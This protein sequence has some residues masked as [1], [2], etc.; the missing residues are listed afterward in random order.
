MRDANAFDRATTLLRRGDLAGAED[1]CLAALAIEP[2]RLDILGLAGVIALMSHRPEDAE[3]RLSRAVALEPNSFDNLSNLGTSYVRLGRFEEA[4]EAYR[5]AVSLRPKQISARLHLA[6]AY[7]ALRRYD[8]A[9][10]QL[11]PFA[12]GRDA[13]LHRE[14][15]E[16]SVLAG[17]LQAG[18]RSLRKAV[19]GL[20]DPKV[21]RQKLAAILRQSGQPEEAAREYRRLAEQAPEDGAVQADLGAAL[22]DMGDRAGAIAAYQRAV[23]L[24]PHDAALRARLGQLH[25]DVVPAWHFTMLGDEAR[26]TAYDAAIRAAVQP[27]AVVLDIGTGSGLLAMMAARAGAAHVYAC[28]AE[29]L[30]ADKAREIVAANG[31]SD[32]ITVIGKRSFDLRVGADLPVRAD[33]LLSEIVDV[34]LLGEGVLE[35][36][37]H[38]LASLVVPG[39]RIIPRGGAV[40]AMMVESPALYRQDR[41][42]R[43]TGFD[44]SGFNQFS[45]FSRFT[46]DLRH[47]PHAAL[48][49]PVELFRFDFT[50]P[51]AESQ[52]RTVEFRATRPGTCHAFVSWFELVLDDER[53]I[54]GA[55]GSGA[56]HWMQLIQPVDHSRPV[57][58]GETVAV[59]ASHDRRHIYLSV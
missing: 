48:S 12:G 35:T 15:G 37:D 50:R 21:A 6:T 42:Q 3:R 49:A 30:I 39:A 46:A 38:A 13:D 36:L 44:L 19:A 16:L 27:G 41:V 52:K 33:V 7:K 5:R 59:D 28:E 20:P 17:D 1:A 11:K 31:L 26:N 40:L 23:N 56:S 34:E 53:R 57:A 14:F 51:G 43:V 24:E 9:L 54:D 4:A 45:R 47:F 22:A 29:P 32:R 25:K 58:L 2:D 55:P 18:I 8:D 10:A